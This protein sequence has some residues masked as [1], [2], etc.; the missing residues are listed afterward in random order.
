MADY[1][2]ISKSKVYMMIQ[3]GKMPHLEIERNVRVSE[4]QLLEWLEKQKVE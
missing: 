3:S 1:L 2:K 4:S